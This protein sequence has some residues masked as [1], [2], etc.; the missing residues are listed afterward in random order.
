MKI[1]KINVKNFRR[2]K[3]IDLVFSKNITLLDGVRLSTRNWA[4][5]SFENELLVRL[6]VPH[7]L[8]RFVGNSV[9][10]K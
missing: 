9:Y 5:R 6:L 4:S 3:D 7:C 8:F 2:F 1:K 10:I